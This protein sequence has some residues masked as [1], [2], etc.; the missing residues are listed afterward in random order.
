M[1]LAWSKGEAPQHHT[2]YCCSSQD[3][4]PSRIQ[5]S[6]HRYSMTATLS[7]PGLLFGLT[8]SLPSALLL[9]LTP[10]LLVRF[11][12]QVGNQHH[13]HPLVHLR[14]VQIPEAPVLLVKCG[15]SQRRWHR[16]PE[17]ISHYLRLLNTQENT[18]PDENSR[19]YIAW[20]LLKKYRTAA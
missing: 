3:F 17:T 8:Y 9:S 5:S 7:A 6:L 14:V 13:C 20:L 2:Q 19:K 16:L 4:L 18:L 1:W 12:L 10:C 15:L 11:Q